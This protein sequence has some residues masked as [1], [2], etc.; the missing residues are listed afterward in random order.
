MFNVG[1]IVQTQHLHQKYHG[2][3]M[4]IAGRFCYVSLF[5]GP[6]NFSNSVPY[7]VSSVT[8]IASSQ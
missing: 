6:I 8:L 4:G 5:D 2:I 3:V 1:D 7:H